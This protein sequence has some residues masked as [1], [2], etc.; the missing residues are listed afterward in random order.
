MKKDSISV[1]VAFAILILVMSTDP[2]ESC[3]V[4]VVSGSVTIDGRPL[5]WKNRD[6]ADVHNQEVR[7]FSDGSHGGYIAIVTTGSDETTTAYVGVNEE[8]FAI[9]NSDAPDLYTGSP[10][11]DGPFMK[12][13][14]MECGSVADFESLLIATS[15]NRGYIWSNFGVID[16][17][18]NAAVFETNDWDY[19]RYDADSEGGFIVRANFSFWGGGGSGGRYDRANMLISNAIDSLKLDYRYMIQIVSKDIG[20][21]PYMP[22]G[23]WP[24]TDPALSRYKTRSSVVVHGVFPTEEPRLSTFWCIL[25]EPSCGVSVPLWSY[26]GSP[27]SEMSSPGEPAPMCIEIQEKEQYCYEN[28]DD[29]ATINTNALVG[30]DGSSGI[31]GYSFPIEDETFDYVE[32]QLTEWREILPSTSEMA[33]FVSERVSRIYT[34]FDNEVAPRDEGKP[35]CDIDVSGTRLGSYLDT[36]VS[37]NVCELIEEQESKG[38]PKERYSYL[39][40]KWNIFVESGNQITFFLEAYHNDNLEGDDFIFAY[41]TDDTNYTDMLTVTKT[42][43]DDTHQSFTLP[44]YVSGKIYIRVQDTDQTPRNRNLDSIFVDYMFVKSSTYPDLTPPVISNVTPPEITSSSAT[45]TWNTDEY[46]NSVVRY[47]T[48]GGL[49]YDFVASS[50]DM[51]VDHSVPVSGLASSTIYYYIVESTDA[52]NNTATSTEY[53]FTTT[54]G[55]NEL[56][57]FNI[58][59]SLMDKGPFTRGVAEVTIVGVDGLPIAGA[60][61]DGHWSGLTNDTDQF[62]PGSNG[63]GSC[64]SDKLKNPTG[65]FIFT[66]DSV[67]KD[68]WV[69]N[70]AANLETT[71]SIPVGGVVPKTAGQ[72]TLPNTVALYENH[73]NPFNTETTI[74]YVVPISTEVKLIIYDASGRVVKVLVDALIEAGYYENSWDGKDETGQEVTS[75]IY[76]YQIQAG[77]HISTKKMILIK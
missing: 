76:F 30:D 69:Y 32:A 54:D 5:L 58:D 41:S 77:N 29:D 45:I 39:E 33:Q 56:H 18:G 51:A 24:T 72:E 68:G 2:G 4:G 3:T 53:S 9:M 71:D 10:Q 15:G 57:V 59:V 34:Y 25:G 31:Q 12:Q 6:R 20:G 75:G 73:P 50:A 22:C 48:D 11:N 26:S 42:A 28:L 67:S 66:V 40:H 1:W 64:N 7:Y 52:S 37:D 65:W 55:D 44:P 43:D 46:S 36:W 27:P 23:E 60:T 74:R 16:G 14:L 61:V 21:P 8:G 47:D 35:D 62:R 70:P 38:K 63:A 49:G 17:F 13:A 19:M